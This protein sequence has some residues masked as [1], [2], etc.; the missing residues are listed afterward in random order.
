MS[1][2]RLPLRI[3]T[4]GNTLLTIFDSFGWIVAEEEARNPGAREALERRMV[5]LTEAW[6][7]KERYG[8]YGYPGYAGWQITRDGE[9]HSYWA[10][11]AKCRQVAKALNLLPE[12]EQ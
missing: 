11:E 12:D 3:A 9:H 1:A 2:D 10:D 5:E 8:V 6:T 7:P 4:R